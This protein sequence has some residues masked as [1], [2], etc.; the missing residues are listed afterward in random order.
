MTCTVAPPA[1]GA[2][3]I[4]PRILMGIGFPPRYA[5]QSFVTRNDWQNE[6]VRY[7]Q[8]SRTTS[9]TPGERTHKGDHEQRE[10][11]AGRERA[12][13]EALLTRALCRSR[14]GVPHGPARGRALRPD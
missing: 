12:G 10:Y 13:S 3:P 1:G 5:S 11:L 2:T 7:R 9:A 14:A 6:P 4:I 8:T